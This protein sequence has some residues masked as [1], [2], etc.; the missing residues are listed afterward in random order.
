MRWNAVLSTAVATVCGA[1]LVVAA[2]PAAFAAGWRNVNGGAALKYS[3]SLDR[4]DFAGKDVGWAVG[5]KGAAPKPGSVPTPN[6][7]ILR[8][9]A[10]GWAAQASPVKFSPMDVAVASASNAWAVGY[11]AWMT[12]TAIHWNGKK[13][14]KVGYG[15]PAVPFQVSAASDGTAYSTAGITYAAGVSAVLRWNGSSFVGAKV[16]LPQST[17]ITTVDVRSRND[18]WLAGTTTADGRKIT[19]LALHYDGKSWKRI[20]VPGEFGVNAYQAIIYRIVALSPTSVYAIKDAQAAQTTNAL[21]HWDGRTWKSFTTPLNAAPLGIAPDG[22]GGVVVVPAVN[23]G[24]SRYLHFN[25][26]TWTTLYGPARKGTVQV[27]DLDQ[28]PGTKGV[29]SVGL[30][31]SGSTRAPFVEL[32]G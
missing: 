29:V 6:P 5:S 18:V 1:S 17:T 21:L 14:V 24:K 4:V 11:G 28:R 2:S 13:W 30:A 19:G 27:T 12:P 10:K 16:P 22:R 8:Y 9:T 7:V 31:S 3:G 20:N 32:Y 15:A 23:N 26:K 25:G